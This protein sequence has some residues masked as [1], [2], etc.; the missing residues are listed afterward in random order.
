MCEGGFFIQD[1]RANIFHCQSPKR[2]ALA[3]PTQAST[4]ASGDGMEGNG[5]SPD[6]HGCV[7]DPC[8]HQGRIWQNI[9]GDIRVKPQKTRLAGRI[10]LEMEN[11]FKNK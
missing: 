10:L 1:C 7:I 9:H 6:V 5:S 4:Q 3:A 11:Y 8:G 2:C